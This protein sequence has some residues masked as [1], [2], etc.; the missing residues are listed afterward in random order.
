MGVHLVPRCDSHDMKDSDPLSLFSY[1]VKELDKKEIAFI[2]TREHEAKDSLTPTLRS[3]FRG[4][5]IGNESFTQKSAKKAIESNRLDAVSFGKLFIANPDL[6]ERFK[7]DSELNEPIAETFYGP[8]EKGYT[9][10][11]FMG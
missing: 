7:V 4:V 9:D 6:V 10:Y 5:F 3:L 2:F 8:D 1:V 11:S